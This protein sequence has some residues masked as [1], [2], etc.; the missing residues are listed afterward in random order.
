MVNRCFFHLLFQIIK[1]KRNLNRILTFA[2]HTHIGVV[3]YVAYTHTYMLSRCHTFNHLRI[4]RLLHRFVVLVIAALCAIYYFELFCLCLFL[5]GTEICMSN[6]YQL[7]SKLKIAVEMATADTNNIY[8]LIDN[9]YKIPNKTFHTPS[10]ASVHDFIAI[11][12]QIDALI[13]HLL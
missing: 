12:A 10:T 8:N 11:N 13:D 7:K 9:T 4:H 5:I 1:T 3:F 2:P 6:K